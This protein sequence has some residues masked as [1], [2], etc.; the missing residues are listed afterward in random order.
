MEKTNFSNRV[1]NYL[2]H[3][4]LAFIR[5]VH[6]ISM[7]IETYMRGIQLGKGCAFVGKATFN[8]DNG[9]TLVIGRRN[10]FL[11]KETVNNIGLNHRCILSV[12]PLV[13][14]TCH[15]IIGDHCGFS[16]TSI[17]CFKEIIIGNNVRCG[18]NT[19][20]MDGD[21]HFDDYRTSAPKSI[22]IKDNVFL[23]ANVVVKK[24]VTIGENSV[25]GMNS[26]VTKDIPANSVAVGNPC[27]VIKQL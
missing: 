7:Y 2:Q 14:N 26:V 1:Y 6:T 17:W 9:G 3:H 10:T 13:G 19:L 23:G 22:I 8:V 15:L 12:T 16:G 5:H 11:S 20:I 27:K 4:F 25:V 24:G 21:A 18:A